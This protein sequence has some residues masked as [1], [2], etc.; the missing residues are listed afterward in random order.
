M[1]AVESLQRFWFYTNLVSS[2]RATFAQINVAFN[3]SINEFINQQVGDEE[4]RDP[5]NVQWIQPIRDNLYTLIKTGALTITNGTVVTSPYYSSIPSHGNY[6]ADYDTFLY[7]AT[8]VSGITTYARPTSY[9]EIGPLLQDSFKAPNNSRTYYIEDSTGWTIWRGTSGTLTANIT[10]LKTPLTF[11]IGTE[12]NIIIAPTALTNAVVYV[13]YEITVYNGVT[14][15]IGSSITGTGAAL[16]SGAVILNSL[17]VSIDLPVKVQ[18]RICKM[19]ADKYLFS[20]GM[21][22]QGAVINQEV[23]KL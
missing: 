17:L 2:A 14:Y 13:A 7:L 4:N 23:K 12:A 21:I 11:S 5:K 18:E 8:T 15:A 20:I 22:E 1:N 19:A 9:N 16:T 3:D 6:P 10:Y